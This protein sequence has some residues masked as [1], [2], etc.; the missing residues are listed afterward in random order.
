MSSAAAPTERQLRYL[1][2]LADRSATT[3]TAPSTRREASREIDRLR[4]VARAPREAPPRDLRAYATAVREEEV[5][6]FGASRTWRSTPCIGAPPRKLTH[7]GPRV[8]A[9]YALST[10][11]RLIEG[12]RTSSG[13]TIRDLP[14]DGEGADY[15]IET[16]ADQDSERELSALLADYLRTAGELD[17]VPMSAHALGQ[18]LG[19]GNGNV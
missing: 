18:M 16:L 6:G 2:S 17:A 5:T 10:G 1:R 13:V 3:F 4:G 11:G 12:V 15:T 14:A 9:R 8:L 7:P 19:G